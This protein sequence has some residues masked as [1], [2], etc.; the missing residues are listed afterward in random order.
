M[1]RTPGVYT[2]VG[3][4]RAALRACFLAG[5]VLGAAGALAPAGCGSDAIGLDP[6]ALV[7][8]ISQPFDQT[9]PNAVDL[10]FV[11][12]DSDGMAEE[13]A[14]LVRGFPGLV[15]AL[16]GARA[17]LPSLRVGVVSSNLGAPGSRL[18]EC[19]QSARG[20]LQA[21]PR[22]P[23]GGCAAEASNGRFLIALEGAARTNYTGDIADAFAC[24]APLGTA[25][26]GFEQH[27][28]AARRALDAD[29]PLENDG[30]LRAEALLGLVV[31]ADED[32]CS[33]P[34]GS[35][36]FEPSQTRYG[37]QRSFRCAEFGHVCGGAPPP[38]AGTSTPLLPCRSAESDGKLTPVSEFVRFFQTL[39]GVERV[40]VHVTAG[41]A[42]PYT[43][44]GALD[45]AGVVLAPSCDG[46]GGTSAAPAVR[47]GEFA[48]AFGT[49]GSFASACDDS[50]AMLTRFGERI[51][52]QLSASCLSAAPRRRA[53][54]TFDC[55]VSERVGAFGQ[56]VAV[57]ACDGASSARPCWRLAAS[58]DACPSSGYE[59]VIERKTPA[60]ARTVA[61]LECLV[62]SNRTDPTCR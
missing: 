45:G 31:V 10:L 49:L 46:P 26:C 39:K 62:C 12:D 40:L 22:A 20:H 18:T 3:V 2:G 29:Q 58:P 55:A 50:T 48:N 8:Q 15:S 54:G 11:V 16:R 53:G 42:I 4:R 32:D 51:A 43:V 30:F 24:I 44:R 47:L 21:T 9:P 56:Q 27:L 19:E 28:A 1:G 36:L 41:P 61:T 34:V 60:A 52:Q 14:A 38:R 17:G 25:G 59:L 6:G 13:Q 33:V 23:A 37:P 7:G 35:D 5:P 57:P